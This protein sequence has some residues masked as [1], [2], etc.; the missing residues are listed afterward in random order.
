[1]FFILGMSGTTKLELSII[2]KQFFFPK[3]TKN[4]SNRNELK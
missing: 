4:E 3:Q 1:M 2:K